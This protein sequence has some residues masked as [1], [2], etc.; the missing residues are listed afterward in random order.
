MLCRDYRKGSF[1]ADLLECSE[2]LKGLGSAIWG[3]LDAE[4]EGTCNHGVQDVTC[5]V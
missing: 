4:R 5:S 2:V 1:N 3:F